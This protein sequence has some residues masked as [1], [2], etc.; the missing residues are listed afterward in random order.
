ML[1]GPGPN[2]DAPSSFAAIYTPATNLFVLTADLATPRAFFPLV[3]LS[4]GLVLAI[5]GA[6]QQV[7]AATA[8]FA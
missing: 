1:D 7:W 4:T 8:V 6:D 2:A 3:T 5:G